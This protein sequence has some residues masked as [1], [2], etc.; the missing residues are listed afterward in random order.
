M[1][2]NLDGW[3]RTQT[4]DRYLDIRTLPQKPRWRQVVRTAEFVLAACDTPS[5]LRDRLEAALI[6]LRVLS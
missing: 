5:D 1:Y 3:E 6:K 4:M 2:T